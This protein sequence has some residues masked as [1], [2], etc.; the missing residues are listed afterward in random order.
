MGLAA[1]LFNG[2]AEHTLLDK[3][4]PTDEQKELLQREWNALVDDVRPALV[5]QHGYPV[6]TW[7]QGSY[8]FGTLIR[9]VHRHE[10]YDVDVGVYFEWGA[11]EEAPPEPGQLRDWVQSELGLF[12]ANN[13]LAKGVAEPPKERCSR[14]NYVKQFHIDTPV[15]HLEPEQDV[16]RLACLS[17]EWEDSD[18]KAVYEWFKGVV[19][20]DS[21]GQMR[22]LVRY[23]KGWAAVTFS[24]NVNSRPSSLLLTV[25]VAEAYVAEGLHRGD[26]ADDDAFRAVIRRILSRLSN[27]RDVWNPANVAEQLNRIPDES[28]GECLENIEALHDAAQEAADATDEAGA[29]LA[30]SKAF[31]FLMPLVEA[32]SVE[33]VDEGE[34]RA[35]MVLPD[36]RISVFARNPRRLVNNYLNE[37]PQVYRDCD[38][39]FTIANPHVVPDY[40]HVEWTVRNNGEEAEAIGDIGH[41]TSGIRMMFAKE[42]TAY[43]GRHFMDC[44]VRHNNQ[45][46]AM[47]RVPVDIIDERFPARNPRKPAYAQLRSRLPRR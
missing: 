36:V 11:G 25:L 35:V 21:R 28:W 27:N 26:Y 31:S 3:V 38:L 8:K 42:H 37:V 30:W 46:L 13:E 16:R 9:P 47:R 17:G 22:R 4:T 6:S 10:E 33:V 43:V 20:E 1:R 15:Y 18:P 41:R 29:A 19:D 40:A 7:L 32:A 24:A 34:G 14:V 39:E 12:A 5:E 45:V 44:V 23:L 2:T